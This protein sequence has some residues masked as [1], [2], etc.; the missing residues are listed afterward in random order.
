[1]QSL[2]PLGLSGLFWVI[3]VISGLDETYV[4]FGGPHFGGASGSRRESSGLESGCTQP[5]PP[6]NLCCHHHRLNLPGHCRLSSAHVA[7]TQPAAPPLPPATSTST[8]PTIA[9]PSL[10]SA[11]FPNHDEGRGVELHTIPM[12]HPDCFPSRHVHGVPCSHLLFPLFSPLQCCTYSLAF[13]HQPRKMLPFAPRFSDDSDDSDREEAPPPFMLQVNKQAVQNWLNTEPALAPR[14]S[15][16]DDEVPPP[17]APPG[18]AL[19][20]PAS[21]WPSPLKPGQ[22]SPVA[23]LALGSFS[24]SKSSART[25]STITDDFGASNGFLAD[26]E[27]MPFVGEHERPFK[28]RKKQRKTRRKPARWQP[29]YREILGSYCVNN[30]P[31]SGTCHDGTSLTCANSECTEAAAVWCRT[32]NRTLCRTCDVA[33]HSGQICDPAPHVRETVSTGV[34]LGPKEA[35]PTDGGLA[36]VIPTVYLV[37]SAICQGCGGRN[38]APKS[39]IR[40][41]GLTVITTA[42]RFTIDRV[43]YECQDCLFVAGAGDPL[44]YLTKM[45]IPATLGND[46]Q[47]IFSREIV[48]FLHRLQRVAPGVSAAALAGALSSFENT[49][50]KE[51][52]QVAVGMFE[53]IEAALA[54]SA[55][56]SGSTGMN[57]YARAVALSGTKRSVGMDMSQKIRL[58]Q[59]TTRKE[60][61][62]HAQGGDPEDNLSRPEVIPDSVMTSFRLLDPKQK[63]FVDA[64][65]RDFVAATTDSKGDAR[66]GLVVAVDASGAPVV[67][68]IPLHGD[69]ERYIYH[70]IVLVAARFAGHYA[71]CTID[72]ACKFNS[73][74]KRVGKKAAAVQAQLASAAVAARE[75]GVSLRQALSLASVAGN[76]TAG[77]LKPYLSPVLC[78][79]ERDGTTDS[80]AHREVAAVMSAFVYLLEVHAGVDVDVSDPAGWPSVHQDDYTV[81]L[82]AMHAYAHGWH[83]RLT[84]DPRGQIDGGRQDGEQVE[85]YNSI[86]LA[87]ASRLA[88]SGTEWGKLTIASSMR[89][90]QDAKLEGMARATK[91]SILASTGLLDELALELHHRSL[92]LAGT[93]NIHA[94]SDE[95]AARSQ[96]T[97][98][99]NALERAVGGTLAASAR[100]W[101]TGPAA[102]TNFKIVER[103]IMKRTANDRATSPRAKEMQALLARCMVA[104]TETQLADVVSAIGKVTGEDSLAEKTV[105][106]A[107]EDVTKVKLP[108]TAPEFAGRSDGAA[109]IGILKSDLRAI[110]MPETVIGAGFGSGGVKTIDS[111]TLCSWIAIRMSMEEVGKLAAAIRERKL[112]V[113]GS[114]GNNSGAYRARGGAGSQRRT[115]EYKTVKARLKTRA[116]DLWGWVRKYNTLAVGLADS[117]S[118]WKERSTRSRGAAPAMH[119]ETHELPPVMTDAQVRDPGWVP[120]H[121]GVSKT[122]TTDTAFIDA[123]RAFRTHHEEATHVGRANAKALVDVLAKIHADVAARINEGLDPVL[124]APLVTK[125]PELGV[126]LT[127]G[128][129]L[130]AVARHCP[131]SMLPPQV[132]LSNLL[133]E[134]RD[135]AVEAVVT[136][137]DA[138]AGGVSD[139]HLRCLL[140]GWRAM[141]FRRLKQVSLLLGHARATLRDFVP[142]PE[143]PAQP[144]EQSGEGL[145]PAYVLAEGEEALKPTDVSTEEE[146]GRTTDSDDADSST[147]DELEHDGCV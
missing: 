113:Y 23:N 37:C 109:A 102:A 106:L 54:A 55:G 95:R 75:T 133:Q 1:M 29:L 120:P 11:H 99:A 110:G 47:T 43:S 87:F 123:L 82:D 73:W 145:V 50:R 59:S 76:A 67:S 112:L 108:A 53:D 101:A 92:Q 2:M 143:A 147:T 12:N 70:Y 131:R 8:C 20:L 58:H 114:S 88:S 138:S 18:P 40:S 33:A 49:V 117:V 17:F 10:V 19:E 86:V 126:A 30:A 144:T 3:S 93:V 84:F 72:I 129:R 38:W 34:E 69:G 81:V 9:T 105:R 36:D 52:V 63:A 46:T 16:S 96:L 26:D 21:Q 44:T 6:T 48:S 68:V 91:R 24:P 128:D 103:A 80:D 130:L 15:D 94:E 27:T 61:L 119:L 51:H 71:Y 97:V 32:C 115:L 135:V 78:Q 90:H 85:R 56:D 111:V 141:L 107:M 57:R 125:A 45:T 39:D 116:K 118:K 25:S 122:S 79:F 132:M 22:R 140:A 66:M 60:T 127:C 64:C 14:W 124:R 134:Q 65:D 7:A 121:N 13:F 137:A 28:L 35:A 104:K 31:Q 100:T 62:R 89:A 142:V 42:G 41:A 83:C 136:P 74:L 5:W 139:V 4:W 98:S 146:S 77:W